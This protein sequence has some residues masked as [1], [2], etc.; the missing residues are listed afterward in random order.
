MSSKPCL[1]R[2]FLSIYVLVRP[3][4]I[5]RMQICTDFKYENGIYPFCYEKAHAERR[6]GHSAVGIH[7]DMNP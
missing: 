3:P 5:H 7:A 1:C 2:W 4:C 6:E